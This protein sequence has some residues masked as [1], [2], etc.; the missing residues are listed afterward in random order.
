M[1][2]REI[3]VREELEH[4]GTRF[5]RSLRFRSHREGLAAGIRTEA[6]RKNH[7]LATGTDLPPAMRAQLVDAYVFSKATY[8]MEVT[9]PGGFWKSLDEVKIDVARRLLGDRHKIVS[10]GMV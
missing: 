4:L 9:A 2:G 3:P 8:G 5:D 6:L 10:R 1:A 7:T